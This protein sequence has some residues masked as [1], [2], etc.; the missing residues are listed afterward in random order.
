MKMVLKVSVLLNVIFLGG[1]LLLWRHLWMVTVPVP[2]IP[3]MEAKVESQTTPAPVL[4]TTPAP[5][6]WSQLESTNGY[7]AFVA[8]LRAAGCPEPTVED[9]VRGN[10]GRAYAIMRGRLGVS[11]TDPSRWSAQAEMQMVAYFLGQGPAPALE[12][13]ASP[14]L[15]LLVAAP[16]L[17]VQNVDLSTLK[18][19]EAQ[20]QSIASIRESFWNSVGGTNQDTSDPAYLARWQKAQDEADNTLH[21]MLGEQDFLQ[22]QVKAYQMSLLNQQTSAGN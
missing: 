9:I 21:A 19:D 22:Y 5:F 1:M 2:K 16:P 20:T 14:P 12:T 10:T 13:A 7:L 18:L 4:Q 8:S 11:S 15:P 6:R 17:V 3:A